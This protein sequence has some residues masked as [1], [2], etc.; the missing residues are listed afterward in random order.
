MKLSTPRASIYNQLVQPIDIKY[1][2][3]VENEVMEM[4]IGAKRLSMYNTLMIAYPCTLECEH[5]YSIINTAK[6][7]TKPKLTRSRSLQHPTK[8]TKKSTECFKLFGKCPKI[9]EI[10][11]PAKQFLNFTRQSIKRTFSAP[12]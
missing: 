2:D 12:N 6:A 5:I 3:R 4:Y 9:P 7:T 1:A 11:K 10:K 8:K